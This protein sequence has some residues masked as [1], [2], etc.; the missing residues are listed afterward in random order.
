MIAAAAWDPCTPLDEFI[1]QKLFLQ[2]L[3]QEEAFIVIKKKPNRC[4]VVQE[5]KKA[6]M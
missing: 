5:A 3:Q 6:Y 2:R 4:H 1:G